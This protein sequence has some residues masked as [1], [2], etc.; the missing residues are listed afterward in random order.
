MT[1]GE[2]REEVDQAW[3]SSYSPARNREVVE[4]LKDRPVA[5]QII[6]V[7]ARIAFRGIYFP[8]M[9]RL[10]WAGVL[11]RTAPLMMKL[12]ARLA[13]GRG[14]SGRSPGARTTEPESAAVEAFSVNE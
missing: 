3:R 7:M 10:Q 4:Y 12:I 8:Q 9:S 1:I 14:R 11:G 2:A 13:M 5:E 6:H